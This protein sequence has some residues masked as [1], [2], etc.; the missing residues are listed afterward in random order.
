MKSAK[1]ISLDIK[2]WTYIEQYR[3]KRGLP[4]VS[5]AVEELLSRQIKNLVVNKW[6]GV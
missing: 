5:A 6:G 4:S 2:Y 3:K 1:S